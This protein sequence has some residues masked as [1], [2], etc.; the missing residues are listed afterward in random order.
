MEKNL[1]G[2]LMWILVLFTLVYCFL[3][4]TTNDSA[5]TYVMAGLW[6]IAFFL[7]IEGGKIEDRIEAR[8]RRERK[9]S[10]IDCD[11]HKEE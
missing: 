4:L 11:W 5:F 6:S 10:N 1:F 7:I 9:E 3:P 8:K 2:F